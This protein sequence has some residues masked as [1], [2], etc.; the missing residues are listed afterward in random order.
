MWDG[1]ISAIVGERT[2]S[3][4]EWVIKTENQGDINC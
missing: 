3:W 1:G 4:R 2:Y